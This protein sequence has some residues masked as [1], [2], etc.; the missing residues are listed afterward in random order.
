[1]SLFIVCS[2]EV[3]RHSR[4][5]PSSYIFLPCESPARSIDKEKG[6]YLASV[7][8]STRTTFHCFPFLWNVSPTTISKFSWSSFMR[9]FLRA[10]LTPSADHLGQCIN[11][12]ARWNVNIRMYFVLSA[13]VGSR[14]TS[15]KEPVAT[16]RLF[17]FFRSVYYTNPTFQQLAGGAVLALSPLVTAYAVYGLYI[18]FSSNNYLNL[19]ATWK[20]ISYS[21]A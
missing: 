11:Y 13:D 8:T 14:C 15:F 21:N 18:W 17:L 20:L 10:R 6:T 1:M 9:A 7:N 4:I 16:S 19:I 5:L 12:E 3:E 2:C